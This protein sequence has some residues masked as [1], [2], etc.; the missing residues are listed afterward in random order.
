MCNK[1]FDR[2]PKRAQEA[3]QRCSYAQDKDFW[4]DF[5]DGANDQYQQLYEVASATSLPESTILAVDLMDLSELYRD[6]YSA[7]NHNKAFSIKTSANPE[8]SAPCN[9]G[10]TSEMFRALRLANDVYRNLTLGIYKQELIV[11]KPNTTWNKNVLLE[12]KADDGIRNMY[13]A[14][15]LGCR[16]RESAPLFHFISSTQEDYRDYRN[17]LTGKALKEGGISVDAGCDLLIPVSYAR[18]ALQNSISLKETTFGAMLN[19]FLPLNVVELSNE[20]DMLLKIIAACLARSI[21]IINDEAL[22]DLCIHLGVAF[23]IQADK[24]MLVCGSSIRTRHSLLVED[25]ESSDC[26]AIQNDVLAPPFDQGL[27]DA[28]FDVAMIQFVLHKYAISIL[29]DQPAIVLTVNK[30][31]GIKVSGDGRISNGGDLFGPLVAQHILGSRNQSDIQVVIGSNK[32]VTPSIAVVGSIAQGTVREPNLVTWGPGIIKDMKVSKPAEGAQIIAVRGP[33][34]RDLLLA[35]HGLN[36]M[37]IGDPALIAGDILKTNELIAANGTKKQV[38]FVIHSV[39]RK[40]ASEYCPFCMERLVNNYNRNPRLIL[41]SLAGCERVVSSSLHGC[42]FAH[43][44]A[45]PTLPIALGNR[46]TGGDFKYID[47]MHSV[48]VMSFQSRVNIS[49][50]WEGNHQNL[51]ENEW[52]NMVDAMPQPQLPIQTKHFYDAFP[53]IV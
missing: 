14:L 34:T 10:F 46:I 39:D 9:F 50:I 18:E 45:I 21:P 17:R 25:E 41:E 19:E 16:T 24:R 1:N 29:T 8:S 53:K 22:A 47:Y 38:C 12:R 40:Y 37:V 35:Q 3:C 36:P 30:T 4:T 49:Q 31:L 15:P 44:L 20:G 32:T 6:L 43:A 51:T 26:V 13:P 11:N 2:R 7:T 27:A 33:R 28:N 52:M 48:G 23:Y 42:I 5:L